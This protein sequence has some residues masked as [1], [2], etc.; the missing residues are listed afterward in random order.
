[1]SKERQ[2]DLR[3]R[4]TYG[5]TLKQ[6]KAMIKAQGGVCAICKKKPPYRLHTD[7]NHKTGVVRGGLCIRCNHRLLGRGLEDPELHEQAAVYLRG[8]TDWRNA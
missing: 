7:H 4:R 1:M 2:R 8:T 5:L 6:W 3:L